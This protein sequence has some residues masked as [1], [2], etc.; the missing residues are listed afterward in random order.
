MISLGLFVLINNS[1]LP[2]WRRQLNP[3]A[4]LNLSWTERWEENHHVSSPALSGRL[5]V[6]PSVYEFLILGLEVSTYSDGLEHSPLAISLSDG[7]STKPIG[8]SQAQ[9]KVALGSEWTW[10]AVLGKFDSVVSESSLLW[11]PEIFPEGLLQTFGVEGSQRW[12]FFVHSGQFSLNQ[13]PESL[14]AGTKLRRTWIFQN[15]AFVNYLPSEGTTFRGGLNHYHFYGLS[16]AL[17]ERAL[18]TGN[19]VDASS[20]RFLENYSPLEVVVSAQANPLGIQ[21]RILG[22][23]GVNL[24]TSN[25]QRGFLIEGSLGN[26][27]RAGHFVLHASY[28]YAEPDLTLSFLADY[29]HGYLNRKGPRA[30]ISYYILSELKIA[31]SF[32]YLEALRNSPYQDTRKEL[33]SYVEFL[34]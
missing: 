9:L 10:T 13:T 26:H 1:E 27:R 30:E 32:A 11:G 34:F 16:D 29:R 31:S 21:A 4:R 8:I 17:G 25:R 18:L 22:A 14:F 15:A 7:S 3:E 19:T 6:F 20:N 24:R 2:E 28:Y 33:Q 12:K 5:G 23:F